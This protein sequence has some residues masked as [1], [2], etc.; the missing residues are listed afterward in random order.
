MWTAQRRGSPT[1]KIQSGHDP[2]LPI[3]LLEYHALLLRR[4]LCR[5]ASTIVLLRP[6]AD[7][8]ELSGRFESHDPIGD[9][10]ITF[11]YRVIRLWER[12]VEELL[13]GGIGILPLAP[14]VVEPARLPDVIAR[15]D[16][17]FDREVS[18]DHGARAVVRDAA[19]ARAAV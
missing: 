5:V 3:R 12:P 8:P 2:L 1:S 17:R 13:S 15:L 9:V 6:E 4:H 10:S 19:P 16:E 11:E 18:S 7:G 14:L